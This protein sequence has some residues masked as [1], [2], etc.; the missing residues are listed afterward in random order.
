MTSRWRATEKISVTLTLMP[1]ASTRVIAGRPSGVA[2]ILII[3]LGRS[4]VF[5]RSTASVTV[6]S[7]SW[8]LP[9]STSSETRPSLP[10]VDCHTLRNTSQARRTSSVV[11]SRIASST[12]APWAASPSSSSA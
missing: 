4:T 3:R 1:S 9:G 10:P 2:G 8:A 5:H 7:V 11:S 6:A 12:E